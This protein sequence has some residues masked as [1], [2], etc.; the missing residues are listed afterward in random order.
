[1]AEI[2]NILFIEPY[3]TGSHRAWIEG[4]QRSSGHTIS[5]LTL[6]GAHWKWRMSAAAITLAE[7][8]HSLKDTPDLIVASDMLDLA[9]FQSLTRDRTARTPFAL[10]FHEN[11]LTY[12]W[13][14]Q[15]RDKSHGR[16]YHYG[17]KNITSALAANTVYFNSGFHR[18]SFLEASES[19]LKGMPRPRELSSVKKIREKSSVLYLGLELEELTQPSERASN[20]TPIILWN[21]RWEYDKNPEEFFQTLF[22]LSDENY[23]FSLIVIG[24]GEESAPSIFKE[25]KKKLSEKILHWGYAESRADYITLIKQADIVPVTSNQ[26]FFGVSAMEAIA[27]GATPLL[28]ER[29]SFPELFSDFPEVFYREGE[30]KQKLIEALEAPK[31]KPSTKHTQIQD[32]VLQFDWKIASKHYDKVFR[33][34]LLP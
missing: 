10:Y 8:F 1:M 24:K 5:T 16:D 11:Q 30:L 33:E 27:A 29:L 23:D 32:H 14:P 7:E 2:L 12:P 28:P 21:H 15:D 18:E 9:L 25:A 34:L 4:Y 22:A 31:D 6:P 20:N 26:D 17:L 13:S 19:F 3:Y